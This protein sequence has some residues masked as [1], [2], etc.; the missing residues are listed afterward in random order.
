M[1]HMSFTCDGIRR[2]ASFSLAVT[3]G[4]PVGFFLR[5]SICCLSSAGRLVEPRAAVFELLAVVKATA[6]F[7]RGDEEPLKQQAP[8]ATSGFLRVKTGNSFMKKERRGG[9]QGI[10]RPQCAFEVSMFTE[11]CN[12]HQFSR[13]ARSLHRRTSRVIPR[14]GFCSPYNYVRQHCFQP[15][16]RVAT[17]ASEFDLSLLQATETSTSYSASSLSFCIVLANNHL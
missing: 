17:C 13:L 10:S 12:S 8:P 14:P 1:R 7:K 3:K 16:Q 5:L 2:W 6:V 9:R 4:I 11:S 15:S